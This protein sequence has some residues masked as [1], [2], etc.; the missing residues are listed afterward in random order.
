MQ[1]G[2]IIRSWLL[3]DDDIAAFLGEPFS[4]LFFPAVRLELS[5]MGLAVII[6]LVLDHESYFGL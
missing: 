6:S 1:F 3:Q 2:G 4:S 5:N